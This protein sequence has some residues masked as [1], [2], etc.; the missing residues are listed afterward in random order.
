MPRRAVAFLADENIAPRVVHALRSRGYDVEDVK[1][2]RLS[3]LSDSQV[4]RMAQ[5]KRRVILTHDRDFAH[6]LFR[7]PA[8]HPGIVIMRFSNQSPGAVIDRLL[9][10][11][12]PRVLKRLPHSVVL[13]TDDSVTIVHS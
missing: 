2:R 7:P 12:Q 10:N 8:Q 9:S 13:I 6:A 11:L 1:E 3:G 5:K 4:L